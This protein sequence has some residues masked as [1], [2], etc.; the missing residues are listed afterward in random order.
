MKTT[1]KINIQNLVDMCYAYGLRDIVFSPGSRNAPLVIAF[2]VDDRF[3]VYCIPDERVAAFFAL[4]ISLKKRIPCMLCCTSGTAA[5]NYAPTIAEAYYQNIPLL[6]LTA[7]R[8]EDKIDQG[9]GQ[10]MSDT[11]VYLVLWSVSC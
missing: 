7:D 11:L 3:N 5:L 8:P 9:I 1:N 4:G 2:N 6:I 10:S